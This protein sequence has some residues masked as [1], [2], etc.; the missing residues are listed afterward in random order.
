MNQKHTE[1]VVEIFCN[2]FDFS[3]SDGH[4]MINHDPLLKKIT[5]HILRVEPLKLS[6]ES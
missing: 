1:K 5:K 3:Q 4:A 6:E 2:N